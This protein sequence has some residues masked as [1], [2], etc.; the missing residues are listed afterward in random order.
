M[1]FKRPVLVIIFI[2]L[3]ISGCNSEMTAENVI[4]KTINAHGGKKLWKS[5]KHIE[6][7][8]II[9]LYD[10]LGK[11]EKK[12]EQRHRN[13]FMPKRNLM[14]WENSSEKIKAIQ[15]NNEIFIFSNNKNITTTVDTLIRKYRI[16]F[17]CV[18]ATI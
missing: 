9:V 11:I 2:F 17:L 1:N 10:S 7:S 3:L 14:Y 4:K 5:F 8:K 13:E 16:C 15:T 12:I 6:Y 18:L